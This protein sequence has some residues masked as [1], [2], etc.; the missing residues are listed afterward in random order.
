MNIITKIINVIC[1]KEVYGVVI[2]ILL[3]F[4]LYHIIARVLDKSGTKGETGYERKKRIT[5]TKI[6]KNISK[7]IILILAILT[8][9]SIFEINIKGMLTGLGITATILGLALQDTL[10]D[11][12]NG[13]NL[14]SENY[15]IV[16]DIVNYNDFTGEVIE[17]G[18]RSTK[19]KN[20]NG[21]V[22]IVANRNIMEIR[23]LSQEEPSVTVEISVA[24]E[25]DNKKIEHIIKKEILP[26]LEKLTEVYEESAAYLGIKELGSN[27]VNHLIKFKCKRESHWQAKRDANAII[28]NILTKQ[29]IRIPYPQL[30]VHHES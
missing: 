9:L 20:A 29:G 6:F 14:L 11:I 22:L 12:I 4:F 3:S 27:S 8:I 15:F 7:Y 25:E 1:K 2:T 18:F 21:E 16:G 10:K 28:Y 23:N 26:A 5:I 13:V 19:I 30:E 17:F 24:Y